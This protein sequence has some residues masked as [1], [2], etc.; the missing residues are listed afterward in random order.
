MAGIAASL[1]HLL[2]IAGCVLAGVVQSMAWLV[3]G[4]GAVIR[5]LFQLVW[6]L[7][8]ESGRPAEVNSSRSLRAG[9]IQ[10]TKPE[11]LEVV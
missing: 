10:R 11:R 3:S 7:P 5:F 4:I 6:F 2:L 8:E 1:V 9:K